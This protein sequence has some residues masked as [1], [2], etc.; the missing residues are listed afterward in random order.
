MSFQGNIAFMGCGTE[1]QLKI[2]FLLIHP[3]NIFPSFKEANNIL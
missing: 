1:Y 3:G 2:R